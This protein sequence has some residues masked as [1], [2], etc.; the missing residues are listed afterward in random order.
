M[1]LHR[2]TLT[3]VSFLALGTAFSASPVPLQ[4]EQE[5]ESVSIDVGRSY[6]LESPWSIAGVSLTD[7][8]I[9]HLLS[10]KEQQFTDAIVAA[11]GLEVTA[12]AQPAGLSDPTGPFAQ[13]ATPPT[14][15]AVTGGQ[16]VDVRITIASRS[17]RPATIAGA[18]SSIQTFFRMFGAAVVGLVIGQAYDGT[19]QPFA[20]ALLMCSVGALLLVSFSERGRLFRRLN[21]P[22]VR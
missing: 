19:A 6:R 16:A 22:K 3:T 5:V 20:H 8:E 2:I 10:V 7:P 9:A 21:P 17:V 13:F 11:L 18:A 14:L 1:C 15:D 4:T 12:T